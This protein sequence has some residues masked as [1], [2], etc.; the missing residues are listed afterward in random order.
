M[1]ENSN[2][3]VQFTP[4]Q[5]LQLHEWQKRLGVLQDEIKNKETALASLKESIVMAEK[6]NAYLQEQNKEVE[7]QVQTHLSKKESLA[8]ES[9]MH[10]K[11]SAKHAEESNQRE[12]EVAKK[13]TEIAQRENE[14]FANE[15]RLEAQRKAIS[16]NEKAL[17]QEKALVDTAKKAFESALASVV[18][19]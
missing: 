4:E 8:A 6:H 14:L 15:Q 17:L 1:I 10:M 19:K 3:N 16:E 7:S 11:A 18:W 12:A 9:D 5:A 2:A 13:E